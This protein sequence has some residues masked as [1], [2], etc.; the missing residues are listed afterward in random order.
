LKAGTRNG[1][2]SPVGKIAFRKADI[3]AYSALTYSNAF[4]EIQMSKNV[5]IEF[6]IGFEL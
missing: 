4:L 1:I 2:S 5:I 6:G 3:F